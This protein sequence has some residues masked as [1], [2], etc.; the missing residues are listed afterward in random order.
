MWTE[1]VKKIELQSVLVLFFT[2]LFGSILLNKDNS[3]SSPA[4][5]VINTSWY[6]LE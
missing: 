2:L 3:L 5:G 4:G 1:L 6:G